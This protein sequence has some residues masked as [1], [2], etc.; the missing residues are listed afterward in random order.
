MD[1]T[2]Q[3]EK[4]GR[5]RLGDGKPADGAKPEKHY[6]L[7]TLYRNLPGEGANG[8]SRAIIEVVAEELPPHSEVTNGK[9]CVLKLAEHLKKAHY[10]P[11]GDPKEMQISKQ[12]FFRQD[13]KGTNSSG[14]PVF[15]SSIFAV[16]Q[17]HA[18]GFILV[19]PSQLVLNN[20][21]GTLAKVEFF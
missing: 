5:E 13:L 7:L 9:D 11:V 21:L 6:Y 12:S 4:E 8:R 19:A 17:G 14:A 18:L 1:V 2:Q 15:Q 3:L 16:T 20:M 10:A